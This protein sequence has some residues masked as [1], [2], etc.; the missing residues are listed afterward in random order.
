MR[1]TV[2]PC[3]DTC[4]LESQDYTYNELSGPRDNLVSN[5]CRGPF[6]YTFTWKIYVWQEVENVNG[7]RRTT[8]VN[9]FIY[10]RLWE[11]PYKTRLFCF[12]GETRITNT[13]YMCI[14]CVGTIRCKKNCKLKIDAYS[15]TYIYT[16]VHIHAQETFEYVGSIGWS[17]FR[18][19]THACTHIY[20]HVHTCAGNIRVCWLDW[21]ECVSEARTWTLVPGSK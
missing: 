2:I 15:Y 5:A 14:T 16:H 20:T 12:R 17:A 9:K 10:M 6:P 1:V 4:P 18:R 19:N 8:G 11:Q 7:T 13:L 3:C 21:M